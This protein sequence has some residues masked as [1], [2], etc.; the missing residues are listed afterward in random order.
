[1]ADVD[2]DLA[3][4]ISDDSS[5]YGDDE[6]KAKLEQQ[7]LEYDPAP[8]WAHHEHLLPVVAA[9][10]KAK[11]QAQAQ[12]SSSPNPAEKSLYNLYE[13]KPCGRQLN[14]SVEQFLKRLP[15][16]TTKS[17]AAYPWIYIANPYATSRPTDS[18]QAGFM[19]DGEQLLEEFGEKKD[20]IET[21]MAGKAKSTITRKLTPLR[22]ALE[23]NLLVKAKEKGFTSGKWMLFPH[24]DDVNRL[25]GIVAEATVNRELGHA[26]KVAPDSG[27]GDQEPRLICVYTKDFSDVEDVKRVLGKMVDLG[28]VKKKK[29]S[30]GE[31][32]GIRYKADAFTELG[33]M[34]GNEWGLKPSLY[35]SNDLLG[36][37][38]KKK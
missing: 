31:E 30:M 1:M 3:S 37:G 19:H 17:S 29:G 22:K 33:I 32:R 20:E 24:S 7:A 14:E 12:A 8:Y 26:A 36:N 5:F 2:I 28:L 13:G 27:E 23:E 6:T 10:A 21:S 35:G 18:D 4:F 16:L 9:K 11:A 15:P 38:K 34:S 25:W